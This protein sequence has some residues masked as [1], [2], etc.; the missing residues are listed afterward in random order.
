MKQDK[1]DKSYV[2]IGNNNKFEGDFAGRDMKKIENKNFFGSNVY[3]IPKSNV[4]IENKIAPYL[5]KNYGT[6][7][8]GIIGYVSLFAGLIT[9]LTAL[10]SLISNGGIISNTPIFSETIS[11]WVLGI[12][13]F[14]LIIG[15]LLIVALDYYKSTKCKNCG[16]DFAYEESENP[17]VQDSNIVTKG[18]K[19]GVWRTIYSTYK[20]KYCKHVDNRE[21]EPHFVE[22]NDKTK[23]L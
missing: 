19:I 8:I 2:E 22:M 7:K 12:G 3:K 9:I 23:I 18:D 17:I 14:F 4:F 10:Y 20:C 13:I 1:Y 15:G 21:S 5:I 6:T 16:E 11:K